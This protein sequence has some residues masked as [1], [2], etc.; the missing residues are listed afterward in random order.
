[1]FDLNLL[2]KKWAGCRSRLGCSYLEIS[3]G[4]GI[5]EEL[6]LLKFT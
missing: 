6:Y 2:A 1:M 4:T 5:K 3:E